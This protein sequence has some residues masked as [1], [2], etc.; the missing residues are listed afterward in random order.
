MNKVLWLIF[1]SGCHKFRRFMKDGYGHVSIIY[2]DDFNWILLAPN[3]YSLEV[4]ILPYSTKDNAPG[5]LAKSDSMKVFRVE[6]K[7][8]SKSKRFPRLLIG[9]TCVSF[10]KYFLGY[11]DLSITPFQLLNNLRKLKKNIINFEEL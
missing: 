10:V 3:E 2:K 4:F 8:T 1:R 9:F 7:E 5:W 11:K 6:Y